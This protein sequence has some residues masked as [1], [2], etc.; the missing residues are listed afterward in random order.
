MLCLTD[1]TL[2]PYEKKLMDVAL[3]S[4]Q[5]INRINHYH[6]IVYNQLS[7]KLRNRDIEHWLAE[8]TNPITG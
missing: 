3:L 6:R 1:L 5:E 8:K 4:R 7:P 2:F